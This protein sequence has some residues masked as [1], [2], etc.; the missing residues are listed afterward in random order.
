M[1]LNDFYALLVGLAV[2]FGF[3]LVRLPIPAPANLGG[4]LAVIGVGLGGALGAF[5]LNH[6]S[7]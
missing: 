7:R 5:V 4:I 2:G 3:T 1:H 6:F